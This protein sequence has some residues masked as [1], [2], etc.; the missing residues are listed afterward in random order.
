[1]KT[2]VALSALAAIA[3]AQDVSSL[4]QCGQ[5][6]ANNMLAASKAQELGCSA[7]DLRCLCDNANFGFGLRDCSAAICPS[8]DAAQATSTGTGAGSEST[9]GSGSET[10]GSE[11]GNGAGAS[12]TQ[13]S[14]GSETT[15]AP[16]S[17]E[18]SGGN[19]GSSSTEGGAGASSTTGSQNYAPQATAQVGL[20][21][22][23]AGIAA[24]M[25]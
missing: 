21:A 1:M 20:V 18:G 17:S 4:A 6:C 19:G 10:T 14:N 13:G 16:T 3:T 9:S 15:Q 12:S 2:F 11:S 8:E 23:A 7:N 5:T 24:L 25:L 22:A